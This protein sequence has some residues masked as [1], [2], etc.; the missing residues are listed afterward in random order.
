MADIVP[1]VE[2]LL[3]R[4]RDVH[5]AMTGGD[6]TS[7]AR[8]RAELLSFLGQV[9]GAL[10]EGLLSDASPSEWRRVLTSF[11]NPYEKRRRFVNFLDAELM[12]RPYVFDLLSPAE[13]AALPADD[14]GAVRAFL[15][16]L[17]SQAMDDGNFARLQD[18][19]ARVM[20]HGVAVVFAYLYA[21]QA[22]A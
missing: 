8:A 11:T 16:A 10:A 4:L 2:D 6:A 19:G 17:A 21:R 7:V 18:F 14:A 1:N 13:L 9:D 12:E 15:A 3:S 5:D 22:G 20:E